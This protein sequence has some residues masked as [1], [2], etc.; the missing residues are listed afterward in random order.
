MIAL[1]DQCKASVALRVG[2]ELRASLRGCCVFAAQLCVH[3]LFVLAVLMM[4]R[5]ADGHNVSWAQLFGPLLAT[6]ALV[7][8]WNTI[9][10]VRKTGPSEERT[11]FVRAFAV[12]LLM[13]CLTSSAM[14]A[15]VSKGIRVSGSRG[16]SVLGEVPTIDLALGT[17]QRSWDEPMD[18]SDTSVF[19]RVF[20]SVRAFASP[21]PSRTPTDPLSHWV[22]LNVSR[23]RFEAV[24]DPALFD[25]TC[26]AQVHN[27]STSTDRLFAC[28]AAPEGGNPTCVIPS[29]AQNGGSEQYCADPTRPFGLITTQGSCQLYVHPQAALARSEDHALIDKV[30]RRL[31]V[32]GSRSCSNVCQ[33]ANDGECD[34]GGQGA[35]YNVCIFGEDCADCGV[36]SWHSLAFQES[37]Y[38]PRCGFFGPW[39]EMPQQYVAPWLPA[40][41]VACRNVCSADQ[42]AALCGWTPPNAAESC[43]VTANGT[44]VFPAFHEDGEQLEWCCDDVF[45][46]PDEVEQVRTEL[47][48]DPGTQSAGLFP[49]VD[50]CVRAC[51]AEFYYSQE[52]CTLLQHN[53]A[54]QRC[55]RI[56]FQDRV[57]TKSSTDASTLDCSGAF[58]ASHPSHRLSTTGFPRAGPAETTLGRGRRDGFDQVKVGLHPSIAKSAA[59]WTVH[60]VVP[61][62]VAGYVPSFLLVNEDMQVVLAP[63]V[64]VPLVLGLLIV[65]VC[66]TPLNCLP[67]VRI[68]DEDICWWDYV[69]FSSPPYRHAQF[70]NFR[71]LVTAF[72]L[73]VAALMLMFRKAVSVYDLERAHTL[74]WGM[75]F[76]PFWLVAVPVL[77]ST[78][79]LSHKT[80]LIFRNSLSLEA[81]RNPLAASSRRDSFSLS[82]PK[83]TFLVRV[84][85]FSCVVATP[86][87]A[88]LI[89]LA[90]RLDTC[91]TQDTKQVEAHCRTTALQCVIPLLV[92]LGLNVLAFLCYAYL[93]V[94]VLLHSWKINKLE[95][96]ELGVRAQLRA[97][98]AAEIDGFKREF[99]SPAASSEDLIRILRLFVFKGRDLFISH[100]E[101]K[102]LGHSK[103]VL[104]EAAGTV[105]SVWTV[106]VAQE[107][108]EI[109]QYLLA[110]PLHEERMSRDH[111]S[112]VS[113]R[114]R[115]QD[116]GLGSV[117]GYL[118]LALTPHEVRQRMVYYVVHQEPDQAK[119][120][121]QFQRFLTD[122]RRIAAD[123]L[124][125]LP[126]HRAPPAQEWMPAV[127]RRGALPACVAALVLVLFVATTKRIIELHDADL[128]N[129]GALRQVPN[130]ETPVPQWAAR[131][132]ALRTEAA[133]GLELVA[134]EDVAAV[135]DRFWACPGCVLPEQD[136]DGSPKCKEDVHRELR[137]LPVRLAPP[138]RERMDRLSESFRRHLC[139]LPASEL[140]ADRVAPASCFAE[141]S[142]SLFCDLTLGKLVRRWV[143][144]VLEDAF[145]MQLSVRKT[146]APPRHPTRF[147]FARE[148][149][150][151]WAWTPTFANC[152]G[153]AILDPR[154]SCAAAEA[155]GTRLHW[156]R[157]GR[158][159]FE[160][161][162]M[163]SSIF[164]QGLALRYV[165]DH[166][167]GPCLRRNLAERLAQRRHVV[168]DKGHGACRG[169]APV[170]AMHVRRGDACEVVKAKPFWDENARPCFST[171]LYMEAAVELREKYGACRVRLATD[172]ADIIGDLE[173]IA[174]MYQFSFSHLGHERQLYKPPFR[175]EAG[176]IENRQW[177][178]AQRTEITTSMLADIRFLAGA[179]LLIGTAS[180]T[181]TRLSLLGIAAYSGRLPA[182]I[183]LDAP[184]NNFYRD[185]RCAFTKWI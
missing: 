83:G 108:G 2:Y 161:P 85:L 52:T 29:L 135:D 95:N 37:I 168:P 179:D 51:L 34:D 173:K 147:D 44:T 21:L 136:T 73:S 71:L 74:S 65:C 178:S 146:S 41:R 64:C 137:F 110:K 116:L 138:M 107:Y 128:G 3:A 91:S 79:S 140:V 170:I 19:V 131:Q 114:I 46:V 130:K 166:S 162:S 164:F 70:H 50:A 174:N 56:L 89:L 72:S 169:D 42:V 167:M 141:N 22:G 127:R 17:F 60:V 100:E 160:K 16:G 139:A 82:S 183:S 132:Q 153:E 87:I 10:L 80:V 75:A 184:F 53:E 154:E 84:F 99:L 18:E 20:T 165:L 102:T 4:A 122:K 144:K 5:S 59:N 11:M 98:G 32:D 118:G 47:V 9:K 92:G 68:T 117:Q 163:G 55:E 61:A 35:A 175:G 66:C 101:V 25:R 30:A 48:R 143:H 103:L 62:A 33:Y 90:V 177:S 121:A 120:Q 152:R 12:F 23:H 43:E 159:A 57:C 111:R 58:V 106:Q 155:G 6:N 76:I 125:N 39:D 24:F 94:R 54:T 105:D 14:A 69:I 38:F 88:A 180:S 157:W 124:A 67:D 49:T 63:F 78:A 148:D 96:L 149:L 182:F 31:A 126:Q 28:P 45:A 151:S 13:I 109:L 145:G 8:A 77:L 15:L 26:L 158:M 171:S 40:Q 93:T 176:F 104:L 134:D 115:F 7:L 113:R 36:R 129:G 27:S 1:Q 123:S 133:A 81:Q 185:R 119:Q 86:C 181:V 150:K 112:S 156:Q 142:Q 172:D 97:E